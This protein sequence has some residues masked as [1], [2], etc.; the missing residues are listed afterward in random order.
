MMPGRPWTLIV[1]LFFLFI[2]VFCCADSSGDDAETDNA[3]I[4]ASVSVYHRIYRYI[5]VRPQALLYRK[6]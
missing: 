5:H 3:H 2:V 6:E 4:N 1:L